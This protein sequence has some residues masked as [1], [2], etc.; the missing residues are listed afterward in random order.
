MGH[1]AAYT[2]KM[3][4]ILQ[5]WKEAESVSKELLDYPIVQILQRYMEI[6]HQFVVDLLN[7]GGGFVNH[8]FYWACLSPI[9][10]NRASRF[11][12]GRTA[13]LINDH[14]GSFE[15]LKK[16]F[17]ETA[18]QCFGSGYV[19]LV[20]TSTTLQVVKFPNQAFPVAYNYKPILS[21]DLWE[22]AYYLKHHNKRANY[23]SDWWKL[24][25]WNKIE[26]ILSAWSETEENGMLFENA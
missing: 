2:R 13:K 22:H 14:F 3:N 6:P 10:D 5:A 25:D 16:K 26:M 19:W 8:A 17:N 21:L 18:L 20:L 24:V 23:V 15:G 12:T 9:A 7:H 11:P 4:E 1:H